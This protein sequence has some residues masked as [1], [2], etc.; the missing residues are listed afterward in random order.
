ME[1]DVEFGVLQIVDIALKAVSPAI[2]DPST[3]IAC[4]DYLGHILAM[5]ATKKP[6]ASTIKDHQGGLR[7][8]LKPTSFP[9]LLNIAFDQLTYYGKTD[10]A[11][12]L[13]ILRALRDV[14]GVAEDATQLSAIQLR[15]QKVF[16]SCTTKFTIDELT[17][18]RERMA[19][20]NQRTSS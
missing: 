7:I 3:A 19:Q 18:L 11:V 4:I 10:M 15:A 17:E 6:P 20:I 5:A 12:S 14:A 8:V 9:R 1:D 13:R 16:D 2:N